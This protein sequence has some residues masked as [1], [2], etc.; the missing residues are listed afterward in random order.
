[1]TVLDPPP[2][3]PPSTSYT[4]QLFC[5]VD[6]KWVSLST[7]N[8]PLIRYSTFYNAVEAEDTMHKIQKAWGPTCLRVIDNNGSIF[9]QTKKALHLNR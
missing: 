1:M 4:L 6:Q 5:P 3:Q 8:S 9:C 2:R 7:E